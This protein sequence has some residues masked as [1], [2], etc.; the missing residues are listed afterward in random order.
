MTAAFLA[1]N[2]ARIVCA[3]CF[4]LILV[5]ANGPLRYL[6]VSTIPIVSK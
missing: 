2:H 1:F 6:R 3:Q 4:D 5:A